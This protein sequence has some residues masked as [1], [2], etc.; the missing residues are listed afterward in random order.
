MMDARVIFDN[1]LNVTPISDA[2]TGF[3]LSIVFL[4]FFLVKNQMRITTF[5]DTYVRREEREKNKE[6]Q[7]KE[8]SLVV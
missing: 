1:I 5:T 8:S 2:L 6:P 7:A 3:F 4:F